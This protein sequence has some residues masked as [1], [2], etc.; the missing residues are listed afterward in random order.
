[1]NYYIML[2]D[3]TLSM[4]KLFPTSYVTRSS[5]A[6]CKKLLRKMTL[7]WSDSLGAVTLALR[8]VS[9]NSLSADSCMP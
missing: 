9:I 6:G 5:I 8:K 1:M 7:S 4:F 3:V 2:G